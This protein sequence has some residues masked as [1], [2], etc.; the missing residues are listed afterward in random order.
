M[1]R[2]TRVPELPIPLHEHGVP[3]HRAAYDALRGAILEGRLRP[4]ARLPSTRDFAEQLGVARGTVVAAF[5]Q[6]A[7]EGYIVGR[8]GSGTFVTRDLPDAWLQVK[9]RGTKRRARP[10]A[11]HLS[12]WGAGLDGSTN[13]F[14]SGSGA[15]RPFRTHLPALDAFPH[16]A[17]SRM[18]A[19]AARRSVGTRLAD[20]DIRGV[21]ALREAIA[22]HLRVARGVSCSAE[23]VI[24]LPS[25]QQAL[26][27]TARLVLDPGDRAWMEDP[28]YAGVRPLLEGLGAEI[29]PLPIDGGG[30]DVAAGIERA[31]DARFAYVTPAHQ[32]PLGVTLS[33]ERR[34]ALLDW[35]TTHGAWI[36][37][38]DYDSEFRYEGRPLAA[39]QGLD[40]AGVVIH[41]GSFSKTM[42]PAMR[43]AYVIV[44]DALLDR[45]VTAKS[46]LDRFTPPLAQVA[47]AEFMGEGHFVSHL[48][49]MR[50]LYAERRS[51]LLEAIAS[52]LGGAVEVI[53]SNAGLDLCVWLPPGVDD[54]AAAQALAAHA[55]VATP[56][57]AVAIRPLQRGGLL[58]GFAAFKP[59]RL[60]AAVVAMG[61]A[62]A[63]LLRD[64]ERGCS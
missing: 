24:V 25:V 55:V 2:R 64:R 5:D 36:F 20:I 41:A 4:G 37:E 31:P 42:S 1:S 27:I 23:Q 60:R 21:R 53:G 14:A 22:E 49:R 52:E 34:L 43:L 32:A 6:L 46:V 8:R 15:L 54:R 39:L 19:R 18:V 33:I 47:L 51:A 58:L 38:D 28:G 44:P 61:A 63:P 45:F 16:E 56:L 3:L 40:G 9:P 30:L 48:R 62:L 50:E 10:R 17:W 29:V 26:D 11:P 35:A 59:V 7:A 57:S 13:P 12:R